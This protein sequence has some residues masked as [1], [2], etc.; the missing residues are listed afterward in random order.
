M[1]ERS[2][3]VPERPPAPSTVAARSACEFW[4]ASGSLEPEARQPSAAEPRL[5]SEGLRVSR[6]MDNALPALL[7]ETHVSHLRGVRLA[8]VDVD[9]NHRRPSAFCR[10]ATTVQRRSPREPQHG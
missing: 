2:E 1:A 10:G 8:A 5:F 4:P 7:A 9:G 6:S 3:P